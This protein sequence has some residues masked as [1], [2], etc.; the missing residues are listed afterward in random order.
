[1]IINS[2]DFYIDTVLLYIG[3]STI[4]TCIG[5]VAFGNLLNLLISLEETNRQNAILLEKLARYQ[6]MAVKLQNQQV[7]RTS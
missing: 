2:L 6:Y 3:I 7:N 4:I 5:F 1:M